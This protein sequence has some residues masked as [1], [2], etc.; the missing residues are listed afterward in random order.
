MSLAERLGLHRREL[1]AWALYDWAN[2]AFVTT[3]ITTVFPTYYKGVLAADL[4][5][6]VADARYAFATTG[7]LILVAVMSPLLGALA[8]RLPIKKRL[9]GF[10][11][12]VGVFATGALSTAGEGQWGAGLFWF[13]LANFAIAASFVF[14]DALLPHIAQDHELDRV[15]TAGYAL[16][17]LG[18]GI[19]LALNLAMIQK[20]ALFGLA[21]ASAAA[22]ASFL[23]VA[24]WWVLFAIPLFRR[25]PEP[26]ILLAPPRSSSWATLPFREL[27][28]TLRDLRRY[29]QALLFL[30]AFLLYNDG[31]QTIIRM[32]ALHGAEV[33]IDRGT[34]IGAILLVQIVG[35]PCAFLFGQFASRVGAK[36]AILLGLGV[37]IIVCI[38]AYRMTTA[39]EFWVL[40][41]LVG[42]VQ[43]G[44]QALSRSV[45]AT[46]IPRER[47]SEF[48]GL[49][50]VF[51]KFAGILG[52]LVFGV[53]TT[54]MGSSRSATLALIA[55]FVA[56][57][58][59]LTRVDLRA[60][61][62]AVGR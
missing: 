51:E 9:M 35:V 52:P 61:R 45:F 56:G 49:F 53:V 11:V 28:G 38:V 21:D 3:V 10:F 50:A 8:D 58:L 27:A 44:T 6:N 62:A 5:G 25:V 17:Y 32:A 47:S 20:P 43:G 31:I 40:A 1:R 2:S 13:G 30:V 23:T 24:V 59:L 42:L 12:G 26:A 46:L 29:R 54:A 33:G 4:P 57:A 60:G 7:A 15:S 22:R 19:L 34:L 14:Y 18:G 39:R 16:G 41:L 55:F 48:F 37:Y 36:T